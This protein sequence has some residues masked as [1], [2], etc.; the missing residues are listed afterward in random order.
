MS[1]QLIFG[2]EVWGTRNDSSFP[3]FLFPS[4]IIKNLIRQFV[5]NLDLKKKENRT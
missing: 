1:L 2:V 5:K 4:E 3:L